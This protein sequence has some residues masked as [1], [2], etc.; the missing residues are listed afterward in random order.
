MSSREEI[1]SE[2]GGKEAVKWIRRIDR[3]K[4]DKERQGEEKEEIK[5]IEKK[6]ATK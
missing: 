3:R 1:L 5:Q 2:E 6:R 4:A